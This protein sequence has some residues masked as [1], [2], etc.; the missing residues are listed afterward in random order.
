MMEDRV[1]KDICSRI[2]AGV[3]NGVTS[4]HQ[5]ISLLTI[6]R[7]GPCTVGEVAER[8]GLDQSSVTLHLK[9]FEGE[10]LVIVE[11]GKDRREKVVRATAKARRIYIKD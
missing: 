5:Q 10:N 8:I 3:D 1:L 4:G 9:K 2:Q 6:V 11:A 7:Y